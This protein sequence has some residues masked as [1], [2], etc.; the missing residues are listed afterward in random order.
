MYDIG[1]SIVVFKQKSQKVVYGRRI[2]N[3]PQKS[4]MNGRR[5]MYNKTN[6]T[7]VC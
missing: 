7:R 3:F 4:Y 2:T 1:W 6:S 5:Y